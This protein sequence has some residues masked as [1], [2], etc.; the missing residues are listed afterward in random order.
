K[1]LL[2][3]ANTSCLSEIGGALGVDQMLIGSLSQVG[4]VY[5]L[6]LRDIDVKHAALLHEA[7]RRL[8]TTDQAALLDAITDLAQELYPRASGKPVPLVAIT[9]PAKP[10]KNQTGPIA[11][12]IAGV[13]V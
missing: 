10:K 11:L 7:S 2:S 12:G 6:D 4:D 9:E 1:Q 3:C 8:H 13:V 5:L